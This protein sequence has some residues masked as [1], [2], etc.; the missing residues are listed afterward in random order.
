M[1]HTQLDDVFG[2]SEKS[3]NALRMFCFG[4]RVPYDVLRNEK[5]RRNLQR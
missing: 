1:Q 5:W 4:G 3:R 2:L